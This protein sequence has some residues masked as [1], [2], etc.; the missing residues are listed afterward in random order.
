MSENL[1]IYN[2]SREV[3]NSALTPITGGRLI[4]KSDIN[5]MW[6]IKKLTELFGSCGVGWT[7]DIINKT[8][9]SGANNEIAAFVDIKLYVRNGEEWSKPITGTGGSMFVSKESKGL[10]TNNECFKMALTDAISVACKALGI[11]ADVY[12]NKDKTKYTAYTATQ[13]NNNNTKNNTKKNKGESGELKKQTGQAKGDNIRT[14]IASILLEM[15]TTT[16]AAQQKLYEISTF[17]TEDGKTINGVRD[18][19][20][21]SETRSRVIYGQLKKEYEEWKT[22]KTTQQKKEE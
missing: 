17:V 21:L 3:P 15:C 8:L 11:G 2:A 5:P 14:K 16:I 4:G 6:R 1:Q 22:N 7:Y 13:K 9:E 19:K 20:K 12:W 10:F 18:F